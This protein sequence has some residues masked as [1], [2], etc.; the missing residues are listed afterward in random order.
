LVQLSGAGSAGH[1]NAVLQ[2][3]RRV[4]VDEL[5]KA[6]D[7]LRETWLNLYSDQEEKKKKNKE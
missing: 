1:V 6:I 4:Q 2:V 3:V 5:Q 7:Y